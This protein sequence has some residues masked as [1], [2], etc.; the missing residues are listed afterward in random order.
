M[1]EESPKGMGSEDRD[2]HRIGEEEMGPGTMRVSQVTIPVTVPA[3]GDEPPYLELHMT[4][5][6]LMVILRKHI[7]RSVIAGNVLVQLRVERRP[8][9][10]RGLTTTIH[11]V[12]DKDIQP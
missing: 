6:D 1:R 9:Q 8:G 5:D 2:Y 11:C 7:E 12:E 10:P 4:I 3:R